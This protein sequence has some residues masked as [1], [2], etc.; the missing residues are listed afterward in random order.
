MKNKKSGLNNM[1]LLKRESP[2]F[3]VDGAFETTL[4]LFKD[5]TESKKAGNLT[6]SVE[7]KGQNVFISIEDTGEGIPEEIRE[8][9]FK[10]LFTTKS[11]GQG[12]G[13]AVVKKLAEALNGKVTV[14]SH[15]RKGA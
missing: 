2:E 14:E 5:V 6:V 9:L 15:Q 11:T 12:F 13:L 7:C 3:S 4:S 1:F 8:K 10:P